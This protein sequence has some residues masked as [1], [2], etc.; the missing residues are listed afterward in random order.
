MADYGKLAWEGLSAFAEGDLDRGKLVWEVLSAYGSSDVDQGKLIY[1]GVEV[2][3]DA[4]YGSLAYF[5]T[6][7]YI[8]SDVSQA[9]SAWDAITVFQ[10]S[11]LTRGALFYFGTEA[12]VDGNWGGVSY[13][14]TENFLDSDINDGQLGYFGLEIFSWES[15]NAM[16]TKTLPIQLLITTSTNTVRT[17]GIF[18]DTDIAGW[19]W[20]RRRIQSDAINSTRANSYVGGIAYG[21]REG[22]QRDYWNCGSEAVEYLDVV[23]LRDGEFYSWTPQVSTGK[24]SVFS[25][26]RILYSD[27]SFTDVIKTEEDGQLTVEL[28]DGASEDSITI[29]L[30]KREDDYI[31]SILE[32]YDLVDAFSGE[33]DTTL[34]SRP[35]PSDPSAFASRKREYVVSDSKVLLN[36]VHKKIIG[37]WN[38]PNSDPA[39]GILEATGKINGSGR[40]AFTQYFPVDA[41]TVSVYSKLLKSDLNYVK[42]T[43]VDSLDFQDAT[44]PIYSVDEELGI[45]YL[46]GFRAPE[47]RLAQ[48]LDFFET[49]ILI[50]PDVQAFSQYPYQGRIIIGGEEILYREKGL[51]GFYGCV[52]GFNGTLPA[53][54]DK[55]VLLSHVRQ[56]KSMYGSVYLAYT[57]I[58]RI[59]YEVSAHSV[60]TAN[61]WSWIDVRPAQNVDTQAILQ[62]VNVEQN[63]ASVTLETDS[64]LIGGSLYGPLYFGTAA[65]NLTATGYNSLGSPVE[66]VDLTIEIISGPGFLN[67]VAGSVTALTNS[68]GRTYAIYND[69]FSEVQVEFPVTA[70]V[71]D[72]GTTRMSVPALPPDVSVQ[73][74]WVYQILK[75]DKILGTTGLTFNITAHGTGADPYGV[76]YVDI[77]GVVSQ[78]VRGGVLFVLD[79]GTTKVFRD[80]T[81]VDQR[82]DGDDIPYSRIYLNATLTSPNGHAA[83][84]LES[85]AIQW[86][87]AL[88]NGAHCIL[89]EF[90]SDAIH[91]ITKQLG[92]YT[93]VHP[94]AIDGTTLVFDRTLPIPAPSND[95]MNLGGY[96]VVCNSLVTLDAFGQ[97]PATGNIIRSNQV[98]IK[99]ELANSLIGVDMSEALPIPYGWTLPT[100]S[101]NIGAAL[102]GAN[103]ITINPAASGINSLTIFGNLS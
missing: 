9:R 43:Q 101:F 47:L 36:G 95:S 24:F 96:M 41:S 56:G 80:I 15:D 59:D 50:H 79:S 63:L 18:G 3:T 98:Q 62:I 31:T 65:S 74:I 48:K 91:P 57:A 13:F 35:S 102:G 81:Y 85:Q 53:T 78:D 37:A 20:D 54:H 97:D 75:H 14:G 70:T 90:S 86:S 49:T 19:R 30:Y 67:G 21:L 33:L 4:N 34:N 7:G 60:R 45:I 68:L 103:F 8:D 61:K 5:G 82:L 55:G 83:H 51:G 66:G 23:H 38:Y 11:D 93:P 44:L 39:N 99:L 73:E 88:L 22:T 27:R 52:R 29:A 25:D 6:E 2:F 28:R 69:P 64:P 84:I 100:D 87:P 40:A 92:A 72:G 10:D 89:Y 17:T 94:D 16:K 71:H 58:P 42:W 1:F 32:K 46:G 76:Y 77:D 12:F 26:Q